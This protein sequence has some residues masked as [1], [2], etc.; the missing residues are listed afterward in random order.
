MT[1]LTRRAVLAGLASTPAIRARAAEPVRVLSHRYPAL[2]FYTNRM[3]QA[4][5]GVAVDVRL[6]PFDRMLELSNIA[7]SAR[8]D[9]I[10]IVYATDVTVRSYVRNGWLRPLDDLWAR[11][12]EEFALGDFA[13]AAVRAF[14][15]DGHLYVMPHSVTV[16]LLFYRRDLLADAGFGPPRSIA[17]YATLARKLAT[18]ARAGTV[19]CIKPVDSTLNEA[20][21]Y[22]NGLGDGWFDA[23]WRPAFNSAR[24][25]AAIEMMKSVVASAQPAPTTYGNDECT[26]ALQQGLAAMGLQWVTRARPMDDPAKSRVVG[27]MD[28]IAPPQGHARLSSDG[29]AISAFS[30][31]DAE[32]LFRIIATSANAANMAEAA[33]MVMPPRRTLLDDPAMAKANRFYP[34]ALQSLAASVPFPPLPDFYAVGDIVARRIA[35]AVTG[36]MPVRDAMDA[37]AEETTRFLRDHGSPG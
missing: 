37:A 35:Q 34:P 11:L 17:D 27:Q 6:M 9:S 7:L 3:K 13:D 24:G 28:W 18:P 36:Q 29:Y 23:A 25:V 12:R 16:M 26:V 8:S 10:D 15:I 19:S 2:E 20:H 5:P 30:R 4:L 21:W 22:L 32:T 33:R 1:R 31:Q 14:T